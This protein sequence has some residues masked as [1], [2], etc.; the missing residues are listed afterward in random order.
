[1]N[2]ATKKLLDSEG[3]GVVPQHVYNGRE[4]DPSERP[5]F[6]AIKKGNIWFAGTKTQCNKMLG[7]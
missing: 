7:K 3:T 1:M 4:K 6:L 5:S 2:E